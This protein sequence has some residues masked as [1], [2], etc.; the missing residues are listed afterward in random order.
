[1]SKRKKL[2]KPYNARKIT[3]L[4]ITTIILAIYFISIGYSSQSASAKIENLMASVRPQAYVRITNVLLSNTTNGGLSNAEDYN[5]NNIYGTIDLPNPNSTVTYKIDVTV[6]L[7]SEMLI[8]SIT[9]LN[10]NLDYELSG[11]NIGEILCDNNNQCN[12]GATKEFYLTIKYKDNC[13]DSSRLTYPFQLNFLFES[14]SKIAKIENRYFDTLDA[15]IKAVPVDNDLHTIYLLND[16]SEKLVIDEGKKI[17][18]NLQGNNIS[19]SGNTNVFSNDGNLQIINGSITSDA[20]T[21]G[22]IN[23]NSK[24]TLIL[25]NMTVIM[26]GGRQA[27]YN[28]KG[29]AT[30]RGNS[31]LSSVSNVRGAVQNVS[32][33]TLYIE[34]GRIVSTAYHGV[35]NAGTLTIGISN[36]EV[37]NNTW[38]EII[39]YKDG[40]N[41][42]GSIYFYD[43][44][45][46]G[47]D[48][49][50]SNT[51]KIV[52][53]P[54]N[55]ILHNGTESIDGTT[56][57]TTNLGIPITIT[58]NANG[59]TVSPSS[60]QFV[61]GDKA[62][63]MPTPIRSGH[64][65]VG[66]YDPN[67]QLVDSNTILESSM[68]LTAHWQKNSYTAQIGET[69]YDT[70]QDAINSVPVNTPTEILLLSN[71]NE[72]I[73]VNVGK[74]ITID[75]GTATITN[76]GEAAVI[77]NHGTLEIKNGTITSNATKFA[78]IDNREGS[79]TI[80][81]TTITSTGGRQAVY[82][83][84]GTVEIKGDSYITS[85]ASGTQSGST[86]ERGTIQCLA[87]GE[88]IIRGGTIIGTQQQ[89]IAN[90][91]LLTIGTKDGNIS[92]SHPIIRGAT[93]GVKSSTNF[94]F[95]DGII[96]GQ[97]D[98]YSGTIGDIEASSV[99]ATD[100]ETIS[101]QT[102]YTAYLSSE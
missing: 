53:K 6:F 57:K 26:T 102:Y 86:M 100:T 99:I 90:E 1:M 11:Y 22:A 20:S 92:T 72:S 47:I 39:G 52:G 65:F 31:Y 23:N 77:D 38:P 87:N 15:A 27:L 4:I 17:L 59:G 89:A 41:T 85:S 69:V 40:V 98:A 56:Y 5:L 10:E 64:Q 81:G 54:T 36:D 95:Y 84:T 18:L 33:G 93:Y 78:P 29:T 50:F 74:E 7:S 49:S 13:Y 16:T 42:S 71:T 79:L 58:F 73:S 83:Y 60:M 43:G 97:T 35:V 30:I 24:G 21:N 9:G 63:N 67:E 61:A 12:F 37:V 3:K 8:R 28:D 75:L 51:S 34:S 45:I 70:L 66:W 44:I 2:S 25:E 91:G 19:N 82:V 96:K 14:N 76:S 32:P 94:N 80:N 62:L 101:S 46:K 68:T 88:L 48:R 55:Y